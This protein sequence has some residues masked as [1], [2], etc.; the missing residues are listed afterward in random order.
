MSYFLRLSLSKSPRLAMIALASLLCQSALADAGLDQFSDPTWLP[1]GSNQIKRSSE[2]GTFDFI[3]SGAEKIRRDI[4]IDRLREVT[5][6]RESL[7]WQLP[8]TTNLA[9]LGGSVLA[10]LGTSLFAC[11][12][13]DCGRSNV[14][15]NAIF[16]NALLFGPDD[17]QRYTAGIVTIDDRQVLIAAY[18]VQR[19]NLRKYLHMQVIQPDL[20]I[21]FDKARGLAN[22]L[23]GSGIARLEEPRPDDN[24]NFDDAAA[25]IL[26]TLAQRLLALD[27]AQIYVVCHIYSSEAAADALLA[28]QRCADR[29][30]AVLRADSSDGPSYFPFGAGPLLPRQGDV[31]N[32]LELV[33]P[34]R[35]P[36]DGRAGATFSRP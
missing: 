26:T 17:K 11:S 21:E 29:A 36:R 4:V 7:T 13:R 34:D 6:K 15:A 30:A 18:L 27:N 35:L 22:A 1:A 3:L 19:G 16:E 12:G 8:S 25:T 31:I 32:R 10:Q 20:P 5:G 2:E 9:T 24:G 33:V 28:S 14:W 23:I